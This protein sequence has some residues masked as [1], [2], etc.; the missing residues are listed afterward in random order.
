M[1]GAAMDTSTSSIEWVLSEQMNK[2]QNELENVVGKD[3]KVEE[4]DLDNLEYLDMLIA[5]YPH[6]C[7]MPDVP[8]AGV[9]GGMLPVPY[10]MVECHSGM[11]HSHSLCRLGLWLLTPER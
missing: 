7:N 5:E 11:L 6:G 8:A 10:D 3:R 1:L 2:L 4:S 9:L